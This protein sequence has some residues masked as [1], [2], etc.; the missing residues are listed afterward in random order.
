M[1][2]IPCDYTIIMKPPSIKQPIED[3][4]KQYPV[5]M[6]A[7]GY[8]SSLYQF[9]DCHY[10]Y[11]RKGKDSTPD[12]RRQYE[13]YAGEYLKNP[14]VLNDLKKFKLW[15]IDNQRPPHSVSQNLASVRV[16]IEQ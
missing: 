10:G 3:F 13:R 1:F 5:D 6:T 15:M 8:R 2:I 7:R 16:G 9:I 11:V 12:E 4:L 14:D